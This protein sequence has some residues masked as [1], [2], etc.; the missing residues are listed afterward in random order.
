MKKTKITK[1]SYPCKGY[2]STY[3]V[4]I[5]NFVLKYNEFEI[6]NTLIDLL[7][8]LK[9]FKFVTTLVLEY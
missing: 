3:N 2:A 1:Q 7:T 9:G 6:T 4:E 8:D 5:L